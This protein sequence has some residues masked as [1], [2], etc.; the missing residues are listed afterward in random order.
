ML[1][2][3]DTFLTGDGDEDNY[4]LWIIVTPV[5]QGEVVTVCLVTAHKKTERLV[6]LNQGE[7]PFVKHESAV[8]YIFSK[9][10]SIADIE[11][12]LANRFA[13]RKE[14]MSP[15][16]LRRIQ[17]GVIESDFTPNGFAP[18][19]AESWVKTRT[20]LICLTRLNIPVH[21]KLNCFEHRP[22]ATEKQS[23]TGRRSPDRDCVRDSAF[24]H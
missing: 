8:S 11:A 12:L 14:P 3:G 24:V 20:T 6:V 7:H 17:T 21:E 15:D 10:R 22:K 2:C 13:Q 4:H 19:I 9:I 23:R 1:S 18:F 5:S 16:I